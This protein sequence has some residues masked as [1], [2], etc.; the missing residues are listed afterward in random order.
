MNVLLDDSYAFCK[1]L[2]KRTARNFFYSFLGLPA[3][4]FRAMCVLY[5]FM[6]VSDDLIDDENVP[7]WQRD[8]LLT[9]WRV[10]LLQALNSGGVTE[11]G[12]FL[13]HE[14]STEQCDLAATELRRSGE[15]IFPALCDVVRQY[16]IP[17][18]YLFAVIDGVRMDLQPAGFETFQEL[19]KYC[20]HVAGAVGLCCIHVWGFHDDRAIGIAIDCGLAFQL[21]NILRDLA[22]D[23]GVGRVYLPRADLR[24]FDVTMQSIANRTLDD[25]FV[26]LMQFEVE[27]TKSYYRKAEKLFEYLEPS[28]KPILRAMLR[29]YGGLLAEIERRNYDVFSSEVML[30]TWRKLLITADAV[31]QRFWF[32]RPVQVR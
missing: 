20:Y 29:I 13:T 11:P 25:R 12:V 18:E 31:V 17:H 26:N 8:Q 16:T 6:R 14:S 5:A 30:P 32:G 22:V 1:S 27:R 21:T 2:A 15:L 10:S 3:D 23:V 7:F 9:Q 19:S 24:Q 4:Q 28:G